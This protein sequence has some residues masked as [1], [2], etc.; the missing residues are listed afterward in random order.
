MLP[1]LLGRK[2]A[3]ESGETDDKWEMWAHSRDK[4]DFMR[5]A[6]MQEEEHMAAWEE[7]PPHIHDDDLEDVEDIISKATVEAGADMAA[8]AAEASDYMSRCDQGECEDELRKELKMSAPQAK[9][10][11]SY[12]SMS[13]KLS[14][15]GHRQLIASALKAKGVERPR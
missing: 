14:H 15:Q 2:V 5:V 8:V 12:R 10:I 7:T 4:G 11:F 6:D 13:T 3:D 9:A 1:H